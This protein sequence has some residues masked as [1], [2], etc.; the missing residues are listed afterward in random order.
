MNPAQ[1]SEDMTKPESKLDKT[2]EPEPTDA[3]TK[4]AKKASDAPKKPKATSKGTARPKAPVDAPKTTVGSKKKKEDKPQ[5]SKFASARFTVRAKNKPLEEAFVFINDDFKGRTD[6][7]GYLKIESLKPN[8]SYTARVTKKGYTTVAR[9][10]TASENSSTLSF[11]IKPKMEIFG[12]LI[13]DPQPKADS[14]L[15]DDKLYRGNPPLKLT[16]PWGEHRVRF[17]NKSL[18]KSWEK[19]VN[20]KVGQVLR[21]KYD[22]VKAEFGKVAVSLKNAAEFG[23]GYVYVDGKLW[24]EKPNTTPVEI[25]LSAGSHTI[26]VRRKGFSSVPRDIIVE[27]KKGET[28]YVAFTLM[29]N[30]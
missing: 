24:E 20:L 1:D 10:F 21:V 3:S 5:R 17:V 28:K 9:R 16:L 11:D 6:K 15:V 19:V 27:V 30:Q 22:F 13:L 8:Q 2:I 14:V 23:F 29:K 25:S 4:V 12:T 7:N 26:E 18:N